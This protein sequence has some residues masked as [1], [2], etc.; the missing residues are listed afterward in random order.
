MLQVPPH[1]NSGFRGDIGIYQLMKDIRVP[2]G[3]VGA[4]PLYGNGGGQQYLIRNFSTSLKLQSQLKF[5]EFYENQM[6]RYS[7]R[8]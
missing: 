3:V 2:H 5:E 7:V 6:Q 8:P 4:N 1:P